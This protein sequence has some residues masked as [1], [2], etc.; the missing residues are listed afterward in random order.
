MAG[1]QRPYGEKEPKKAVALHY[2]QEQ[3]SAPRIVA[4]GRGAV[5]EQ[6]VSVA[7]E[8]QVPLH[9]DRGL[10]ET[11]LA[12]ELGKEIPPELYQVVAEVLAFVQ[13]IDKR[14]RG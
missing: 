6:I 2:D 14:E 10:V 5:A 8:H 4:Q 7:K 11:L 1:E 12:F 9:E 3:G 13:H